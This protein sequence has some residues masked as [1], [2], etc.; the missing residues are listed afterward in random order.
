[1][2]GRWRREGESKEEKEERIVGRENQGRRMEEMQ[3]TG[4]VTPPP[5]FPLPVTPQPPFPAPQHPAEEA[6]SLRL[7]VPHPG[8]LHGGGVCLA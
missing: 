6:F 5:C 4:A 2:N 3:G 8:G 1:M 7:Q